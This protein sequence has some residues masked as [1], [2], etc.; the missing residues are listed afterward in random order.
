MYTGQVSIFVDAPSLMRGWRLR[1]HLGELLHCTVL[2]FLV[3]AAQALLHTLV[4]DGMPT[5]PLVMFNLK[6]IGDDCAVGEMEANNQLHMAA[7]RHLGCSLVHDIIEVESAEKR[8]T[9]MELV[10]Q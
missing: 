8:R 10:E 6:C 3:D 4:E 5:Y 1:R 2:L 7:K 9:L